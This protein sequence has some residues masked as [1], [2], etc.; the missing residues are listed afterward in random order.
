MLALVLDTSGFNSSSGGILDLKLQGLLLLLS[1]PSGFDA[2]FKL[3]CALWLVSSA[4][5]G[6]QC[7]GT[8]GGGWH[9]LLAGA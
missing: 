5:A 2:C 9:W 3:P 1:L 4:L 7:A 8:S 6:L